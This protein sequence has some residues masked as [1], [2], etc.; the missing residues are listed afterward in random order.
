MDPLLRTWLNSLALN[1]DAVPPETPG[2]IPELPPERAWIP[3]LKK[4]QK[5]LGRSLNTSEEIK[6]KE[7][8]F[9][10][11]E[12]SLR[13]TVGMEPKIPSPKRPDKPAA[14]GSVTPSIP[15][16]KTPKPD[17]KPSTGGAATSTLFGVAGGGHIPSDIEKIITGFQ[18][19]QDGVYAAGEVGPEG[20]HGQRV[21]RGAEELASDV[22][23]T[24]ADVEMGAIGVEGGAQLAGKLPKIGKPAAELLSKVPGAKA[25]PAWAQKLVGPTM[26]AVK[27]IEAVKKLEKGEYAPAARE[28]LDASHWATLATPYGHAGLGQQ[29]VRGG[30]QGFLKKWENGIDP[31]EAITRVVGTEASPMERLETTADVAG[32]ALG[33]YMKHIQPAMAVKKAYQAGE[34]EVAKV[35][36]ERMAKSGLQIGEKEAL[37]MAGKAAI[38]GGVKAAAKQVPL[39]G[40]AV[41]TPFAI[42]RALEGDWSGAALEMASAVPIAGL[43]ADV[44]LAKRDFDAEMKKYEDAMEKQQNAV[45]AIKSEKPTPAPAASQ[46]TTERTKFKAISPSP[47]AVSDE[48]KDKT[49]PIED[50]D[51]FE[52]PDTKA[53]NMGTASDEEILS[54]DFLKKK[55]LQAMK[56]GLELRLRG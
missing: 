28:A 16:R 29:F 9:K 47:G 54:Q 56:E 32:T 40:L 5:E 20:T 7:A 34:K 6:A 1:E 15:G 39:A 36:M 18:T 38:K 33:T 4:L 2:E 31:L 3:R 37:Q 22:L 10:G 19:T 51:N 12:E 46:P 53:V 21:R 55:S 42:S 30:V 27:G 49:T 23:Q 48:D 44:Y 52:T 8:W 11:G 45:N 43:A 24:A 26:T 35:A 13:K 14:P 41:A 25:I 50:E 17:A